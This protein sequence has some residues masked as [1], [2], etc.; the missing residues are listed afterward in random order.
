MTESKP[1]EDALAWMSGD[2]TARDL[3]FR[4]AVIHE[5]ISEITRI[6]VLFQS[7][8]KD[9]DLTQFIGRKLNVH[10]KTKGENVR[11]FGGLCVSVE[12]LGIRAGVRQYLAEIRPWF[13]MLTKTT[14]CRVFQ[15]MT[16]KDIVE[17]VFG[18]YG[19]TDY[20]FRLSDSYDQRQYCV[21]Y[22]ETD[23]D[24]ICRLLEQ[25]G[26]YYFFG[27]KSAAET[28]DQLILCDSKSAHKAVPEHAKVTFS[29]RSN[30][31]ARRE[32]HITE[33]AAARTFVTGK[34]TIDD[35][36]FFAPKAQK[37][38]T[39]AA[40]SLDYPR[41]DMEIYDVP[42]RFPGRRQYARG[43]GDYIGR[44][45]RDPSGACHA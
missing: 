35:Y 23:F 6:S 39:E 3:Q 41:K 30:Q 9:L 33:W 37:Q 13:W 34:V 43:W 24:F 22:R 36:D 25:E 1:I 38:T 45:S 11:D 8:S 44:R 4:K 17:L 7:K 2:Y 32:D 14:D 29:A 12:N 31:D 26:I 28:P 5:G 27:M 16:T 42:G 10:V 21:Q 18:E 40:R 15:N 20:E 19:F